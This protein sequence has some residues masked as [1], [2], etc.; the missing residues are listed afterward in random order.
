MT[1]PVG[2]PDP[3]PSCHG[4]PKEGDPTPAHNEERCE[5][6]VYPQVAENRAAAGTFVANPAVL[7]TEVPVIEFRQLVSALEPHTMHWQ[8]PGSPPSRQVLR[9]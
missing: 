5:D 2:V 1:L 3:V 7:L 9:I 4:T 8:F 6:C